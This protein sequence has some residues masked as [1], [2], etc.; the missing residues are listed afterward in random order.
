MALTIEYSLFRK[1]VWG[2][3]SR[4]VW[5]GFK[6]N[7][8][9]N[10]HY[11]VLVLLYIPIQNP[12]LRHSPAEND[13][14]LLTLQTSL[15]LSSVTRLQMTGSSEWNLNMPAKDHIHL[16]MLNAHFSSE[17]VSL[18]WII[19]T[20]QDIPTIT[21]SIS[22]LIKNIIINMLL[23]L[24]FS[25]SKTFIINKTSTD[26]SGIKQKMKLVPFI[27][28]LSCLSEDALFNFNIINYIVNS[29]FHS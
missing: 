10:N 24:G 3:T 5:R 21:D 26:I 27:T 4:T 16:S 19:L 1:A 22:G 13:R 2:K 8:V 18:I 29:A 15:S 14:R 20:A 17:E 6:E 25:N 12:V 23:L 9:M 11:C 28:G 7:R